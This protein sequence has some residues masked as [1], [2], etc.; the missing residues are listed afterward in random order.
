MHKN[1]LFLSSG[2]HFFIDSL[3][4]GVMEEILVIARQQYRF[5][6]QWLIHLYFGFS[7]R[8]ELFDFSVLLSTHEDR[9]MI[10]IFTILLI[11]IG[12][13]LSRSSR[14]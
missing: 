8:I 12:I 14:K 1:V 9:I 4:I 5:I 2:I 11:L 6:L 3:V 7:D 13:I 10:G